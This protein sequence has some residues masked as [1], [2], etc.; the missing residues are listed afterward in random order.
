MWEISEEGDTKFLIR[1]EISVA[2]RSFWILLGLGTEM[3]D[4]ESVVM[5]YVGRRHNVL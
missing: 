4:I 3:L 1:Y 2:V 5:L